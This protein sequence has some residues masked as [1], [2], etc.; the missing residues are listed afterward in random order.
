MNNTQYVMSTSVDWDVAFHYNRLAVLLYSYIAQGCV[1]C[2]SPDRNYHAIMIY[3]ISTSLTVSWSG[4]ASHSG[5]CPVPH[6]R[7]LFWWLSSLCYF[8]W[9]SG[10]GNVIHKSLR[11]ESIQIHNYTMWLIPINTSSSWTNQT[12]AITTLFWWSSFQWPPM[13]CWNGTP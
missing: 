3:L 4:G 5:R 7:L 11:K 2:L 13:M 12:S 6:V 1:V 9:S 8:T 10:L